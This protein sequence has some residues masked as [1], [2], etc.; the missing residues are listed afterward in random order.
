MKTRWILQ[1]NIFKEKAVN[2]MIDCFKRLNIEYDLVEIIPF[3]DE[4]PDGL[5][6]EYDMPVV[7]YGTT[8]LIYASYERDDI[9]PGV[10]FSEQTFKPSIWGPLF[11]DKWLNEDSKVIKLKNVLQ[12]WGDPK[13]PLFIRPNSD[14][15]LFSGDVFYKY[16]FEQWFEDVQNTEYKRLNEN[17]IVTL[18]PVKNIISEYRFIIIDKQVAAY[19]RYKFRNRLNISSDKKDIPD[20]AIELATHVANA[21]WQITG[22]YT[23]DICETLQGFY[24]IEVNCFNASGFYDCN[25]MD[26]IHYASVLAE[27]E[28]YNKE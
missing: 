17:T 23:L 8:T 24:I 18:S 21:D 27:K 9:Y 7:I 1:T 13:K 11:G 14:F 25:V 28:Y 22:A 2:H 16:D 3:S 15:K 20:E 10:W 19:S 12:F 6:D 4:L 26:I 5:L